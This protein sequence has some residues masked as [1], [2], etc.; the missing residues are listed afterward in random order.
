MERRLSVDRNA[1]AD[2]HYKIGQEVYKLREQGVLILGSGNVVHNLARI[3]W[4]MEDEGYSW[5]EEFDNYICKNV[6]ERKDENVINY[7]K[8]GNPASMAF[9]TID[10]YAPLLYVLGAANNQDKITVF[11]KACTMGSLSMT[12]YLFE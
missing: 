5:A 7:Q 9:T 12:S 8:A 1:S 4:N 3:N 11:N 6:L 10:H 2:Q